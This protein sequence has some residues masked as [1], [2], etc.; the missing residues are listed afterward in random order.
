M[1]KETPLK[2]MTGYGRASGE[3]DLASVLVELRSVNG[4]FFKLRSKVPPFLSSFEPGLEKLAKAAIRR[5]NV[6]LY[7]RYQPAPG[8][9]AG[10]FDL[11]AMKH[12]CSQLNEAKEKLGVGGDVTIELLAML[13][14][15][16]QADGE[17]DEQQLEGLWPLVEKTARDAL[18]QLDKMRLV[19][20]KALADDLAGCCGRIRELL[21]DV[22]E[23]VPSVR[24]NYTERLRQRIQT[25]LD[26]EGVEITPADLAREVAIF[27]E[28]SDI[29][30]EIAR[31]ESHLGQ[32]DD[33]LSNAADAGRTLEFLAQEMHREANTMG[34]KANDVD[35]AK[36]IIAIKTEVDKIKE[37]V[38]NVE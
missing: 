15:C 30:E 18:E 17:P 9:G 21:V 25:L 19:E 33:N 4:R 24:E 10:S 11:D 14:G 38:P 3:N 31:L 1:A 32:F 22:K 26:S 20:G 2:S 37:Q 35:L 34:G 27:T 23:K 16:L 5:G 7:L 29:S 13:P 12:Y 28:R 8:A 6:D 36:T